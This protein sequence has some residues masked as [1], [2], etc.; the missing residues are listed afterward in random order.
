MHTSTQKN[1]GFIESLLLAAAGLGIFLFGWLA[2]HQKVPVPVTPAP[3]AVSETPAP[4][5]GATLPSG[6]AVFETSLQSPITSSATSLTL[7][8][9]SVS[10][11]TTLSGYNCFTIDEGS[12]QAEYVCGT[13]SGTTVSGMTR[14]VDPQTATT[15]NATLQFSHRRGAN[16][17]ITDFPL[18]QIMRNQ[19]NGNDT[20]PNILSYTSGTAC[21]GTS[22]NGSL[23][24]K[25]YIDGVVVSGASNANETT[26]GIVE[27]ATAIEQASS[28]P[29]G[30][31][32]ASVVIQAKYATSSP[33]RGCDGTATAGALCVPVARNDGKISPN[34]IATSSTDAYR[35]TGA[36]SSSA[37]TTIAASS[38]TTAPIVLNSIPYKF[39]ATQ[40]ASSTVPMN[41]GGGDLVWNPISKKIYTS[42]GDVTVAS[43]IA[44][45][46]LYTFTVP[47]NT[48]GVDGGV[49]FRIYFDTSALDTG[50]SV[51][52]SIKYG[53]TFISKLTLSNGS[54]G[55]TGTAG[56]FLD[57]TIL[58]AGSTAAQE[59]NLYFNTI[60]NQA[61]Q[62][63]SLAAFQGV[64][65]GTATEDST[66]A[67]TVTVYVQELTSSATNKITVR[68]IE[69]HSIQ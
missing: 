57:G 12:A 67:Q 28:T 50:N 14:G 49:A 13:V 62:A 42:T 43:S 46:T 58:S 56:G 25:A 17:K 16:I 38:T 59:G 11:G 4:L 68:N 51:L 9:N 19:L 1:R 8:A 15:T 5:A 48:L 40:G 34:F 69:V 27:L 7:T 65:T 37:T 21:S 22:A 39:P 29:L 32:A 3:S 66:Q 6:T 35:L 44:S 41:Q 53:S 64:A 30:S 24:D 47:A 61:T 2:T 55:S 60:P 20:I 52:F 18:I 36:F 63:A 33:L 31:T 10:G 45:T 54:G 26:K 23:C